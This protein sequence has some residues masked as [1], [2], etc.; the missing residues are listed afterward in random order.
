MAA[1][2]FGLAAVW[3][4][5]EPLEWNHEPDFFRICKVTIV[6]KCKNVME[7]TACYLS[8]F[9]TDLAEPN[10]LILRVDRVH[11]ALAAHKLPK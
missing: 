1:Y 11:A 9:R 6:A 5:S 2:Q 3:Q 4:A 7:T 8:G 10:G